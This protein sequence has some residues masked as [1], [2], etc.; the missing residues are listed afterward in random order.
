LVLIFD[1]HYVT[2]SS[3]H[4]NSYLLIHFKK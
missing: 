4:A 1:K 3:D 2:Y